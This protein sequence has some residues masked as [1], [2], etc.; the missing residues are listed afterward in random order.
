MVPVLWISKMRAFWSIFIALLDVL[1]SRVVI[2]SIE[3]LTKI[4]EKNLKIISVRVGRNETEYSIVRY[5]QV[6]S[7]VLQPNSGFRFFCMQIAQ[8]TKRIQT[9]KV[10]FLRLGKSIKIYNDPLII[11][12]TSEM[13]TTM[14]QKT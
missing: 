5:S 4:P 1:L 7:N 14:L 2:C 10:E 12:W 3:L 11:D 6:Y 9:K 8:N 13:H